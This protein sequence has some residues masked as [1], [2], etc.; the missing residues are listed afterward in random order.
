MTK[1][2]QETKGLKPLDVDGHVSSVQWSPRLGDDRLLL[3]RAKDPSVDAGLMYKRTLIVNLA[4]QTLASIS[5]PGKLGKLA[6]SP[7]GRH[8]ALAAGVDINDPDNSELF[9]A[10]SQT[11]VM[12]SVIP[13][14]P[15]RADNFSW[16]GNEKVLMLSLIHI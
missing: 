14:I 12:R 9:I 5:N 13:N 1:L 2:G 4:G 11:G 10:N 8:V 16:N 15:G 3:V 7:D 6:W